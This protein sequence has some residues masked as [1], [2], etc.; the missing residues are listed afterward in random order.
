M[1]FS[2][3]GIFARCETCSGHDFEPS[4]KVS[5]ATRNAFTCTGCGRQ[6][7]YNDLMLQIGE[8]AVRRA[9]AARESLPGVSQ[10]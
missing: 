8:E 9:K 4:V 3:A 5:S 7:L 1:R 2:V 10:A 6:A